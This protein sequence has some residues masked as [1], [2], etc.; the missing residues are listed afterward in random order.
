MI[1]FT[2]KFKLPMKN[3]FTLSIIFL[4]LIQFSYAQGTAKI[5]FL[6]DSY[7][8]GKIEE[9]PK[10]SHEFKFTN[11]GTVPL[12]LSN[13]KAS[14]GCTT[15]SW[16]KEP[17]LPGEEGTILVTYNTARRVGGFNKSITITSN[18]ETER[19]ILYIRGT[20]EPASQEETMPIKE[21]TMMAPSN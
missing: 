4:A 11:E 5:N 7:D 13:V 18:A 2:I 14:C 10:V 19:R 9:G 12:I 3:I 1:T 8:F 17:I 15:P 20:V 16:P 6:E 21:P